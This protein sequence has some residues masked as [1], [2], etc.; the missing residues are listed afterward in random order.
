MTMTENHTE[1]SKLVETAGVKSLGPGQRLR[2]ERLARNLEF[3]DVAKHLRLSFQR[4]SLIEA[5]D[6]ADMGASAFARGYLR[7][8]A[9]FL[10]VSES[11]IM[12]SF[13]D[14]GLGSDIHSN[15]PKLINERMTQHVSHPVARRLGYLLFLAV[16]VV[17]GFWWHN[18]VN[19]DKATAAT[20]DKSAAATSELNAQGISQVSDP[21]LGDAGK[22]AAAQQV[23]GLQ[24]AAPENGKPSVDTSAA[25]TTSS[26]TAPDSPVT[27]SSRRARNA[28]SSDPGRNGTNE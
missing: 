25:T 13:D 12:Q 5:D 20:E 16:V 4:L 10:N 23:P 8:Y 18:H 3:E 14:L 22:D 24:M 1:A 7:S 28:Y 9:R 17:G 27:K 19:A 21:L 2:T 6:Y 26:A 11:E 15:T